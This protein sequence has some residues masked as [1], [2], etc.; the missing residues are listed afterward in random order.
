MN[1]PED[2]ASTGPANGEVD[3]PQGPRNPPVANADRVEAA[4]AQFMEN[5]ATFMQW[6][7]MQQ[8]GAAATSVMDR[9][10]R[11]CNSEFHGVTYASEAEKWLHEVERAFVTLGVPYN[12]KVNLASFN[13]KG[14]ALYWWEAYHRQ[15]TMPIMGDVAAIP[16]VVTWELFVKGFNDQ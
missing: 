3:Q 7:T 1:P 10:R 9:F 15:L 6:Q 5:Q 11:L 16:R 14:E 13:L 2:A 12:Q 8:A 4:M